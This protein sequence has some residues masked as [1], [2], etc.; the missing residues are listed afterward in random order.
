MIVV[1]VL[2]LAAVAWRIKTRRF[3][4]AEAVLLAFAVA[5]YLFVLAQSVASLW[6][7]GLVFPEAR[8]WIQVGVLFLGWA[9]WGI[10]ELS[11]SLS[12]RFAPARWLLPLV[13]AVFAAI[14]VAMLVKP[15]VPG[16]R[17]NA[18]LRACDWAEEK[19]R[20]DW[21]GPTNDP[22][23]VYTD[24]EYRLPYR[25][26]V[27][28]HT[29]LLTYRLRAR[30]ALPYHFGRVDLPDYIF[31]EEKKIEIPYIGRYELVGRVA[32]GKR[33]FALYKRTDSDEP[34]AAK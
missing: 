17:R 32:F 12:K 6:N 4:K 8:Y 7:Y 10:D 5:T 25:P 20:A 34:E 26:A 31:D 9:A 3:T 22:R 21:H 2:A 13:V 29:G 1:F 15:H 23:I 14:D 16:A 27:M 18:Y 30:F 24:M 33:T 19:I 28:A 11:K